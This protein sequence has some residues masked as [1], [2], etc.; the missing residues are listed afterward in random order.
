MLRLG[1]DAKLYLVSGG[2]PIITTP[3]LTTWTEIGNVRD[4]SLPLE[5]GEA[6]VTTRAN[7]G[8]RAMVGTLK[9]GGVDFE[10]VWDTAD[11]NFGFI[12][13]AFLNNSQIGLAIMDGSILAV[14]SEG[15]VG[16]FSITKFTRNEPLEEALK[17]A[18]TAK[19]TYSAIDPVWYEVV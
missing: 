15:L 6:D 17:V 14:G 18:V 12:K 5:K 7:N 13:D 10:M 19:L 11:A 8:W 3:V 4:V 16:N 2:G 1:L 9:D